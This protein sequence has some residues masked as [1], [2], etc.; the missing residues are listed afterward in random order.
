MLGQKKTKKKSKKT[1]SFKAKPFKNWLDAICKAVVKVRDERICQKCLIKIHDTYNCQWA[2]IKSRSRND[3][4]WDL[5][6]SMVLC[7][8]C[9]QW[10]HANP[11]EAGVWFANE[12]SARDSYLNGQIYKPET[13]RKE[14]FERIEKYLIG[15][16]ID[17]NV[18]PCHISKQFQ[19]RFEKAVEEYK[20]GVKDERI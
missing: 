10:W 9:H 14:D 7:G 15:K 17:L 16:A 4:R 11:N 5:L 20:K 12:F 2:H 1:K 13:W 19:T 18:K 6:N 3:L 8:S